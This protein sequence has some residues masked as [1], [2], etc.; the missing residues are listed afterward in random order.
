MSDQATQFSIQD[1][2]NP[3]LIHELHN[4]YYTND[5]DIWE[6]DH[7]ASIWKYHASRFQ[8]NI[9]DSNNL[10]S[11]SGI[12]FGQY[13]WSRLKWRIRDYLSICYHLTVLNQRFRLLKL[14]RPTMR[15]CKTMGMNLTR[16][17]FRQVCALELVKSHLPPRSD[18]KD[19]QILVIGDGLGILSALLK[20]IFPNSTIVMVD[21]GKT[22][23]LQSYY[24]QK[25]HPKLTH[26]LVNSSNYVKSSDFVYCP[27]EYLELISDFQF[28]I[29]VNIA[30]MQ[31]MNDATISRYFQFLR[32]T[33]KSDNLFYCCNREY[34]RMVHGEVSEFFL[35]PWEHKDKHLIDSK[36]P[37]MHYVFLPGKG[38]KGPFPYINI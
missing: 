27:A 7:I 21:I 4:N 10:I 11:F 6:S 14:W 18:Q 31:E 22:L 35:Y 19:L 16:D 20:V 25:S 23:L 37:W 12:G 30:S 17:V 5:T 33:L 1:L 8:V 29:A 32:T 26:S 3:G 38:R 28:D 9:D 15:L 13:Q 2:P 36:C 34:T 24:V